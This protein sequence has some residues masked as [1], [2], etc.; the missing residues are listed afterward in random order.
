[1]FQNENYSNINFPTFPASYYH[2]ASHSNYTNQFS[3]FPPH[4]QQQQQHHHHHQNPLNNKSN[5]R[6]GGGESSTS[7]SNVPNQ[8]IQEQQQ[9]QQQY[10]NQGL[11][12]F[13][14]P[15]IM[16]YDMNRM[17]N[18]NRINV[19]SHGNQN[20]NSGINNRNP[21]GIGCLNPDDSGLALNNQVPPGNRANNYWDNFRR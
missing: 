10:L 2:G 20:Q 7:S 6:G 11:I 1:M 18:V 8:E 4:V 17:G 14:V 16:D 13:S 5:Y 15:D 12:N 21:N 3:T 9:Q 19:P